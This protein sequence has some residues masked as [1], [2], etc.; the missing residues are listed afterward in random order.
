M[1]L[2]IL[3]TSAKI[4]YITFLDEDKSSI[5]YTGLFKIR[6][7]YKTKRDKGSFINDATQIGGRG[8]EY[9]W[10]FMFCMFF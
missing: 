4:K 3:S 9:K 2:H 8:I 1:F 5:E 6:N 7:D 10:V